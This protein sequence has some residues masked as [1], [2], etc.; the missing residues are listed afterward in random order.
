MQYPPIPNLSE[1]I[2]HYLYLLD[3]APR[4]LFHKVDTRTYERSALSDIKTGA[5]LA[6]SLS[7]QAI[8]GDK[9]A[10]SG[11]WVNKNIAN[12]RAEICYNCPNNVKDLKKSH[13]LQRFNNK[14]AALFT[15][16]R[17]TDYDSALGDCSVCGCPL[18]QKVHYSPEVIKDTTSKKVSPESF[19]ESFMGKNKKRYSCWVRRILENKNE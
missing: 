11:G 13:A 19:P 1:K 3:I 15:T 4:E 2:Q 17:S 14:V 18:A 10:G 9:K 8:T 5:M 7:R 6:L 12:Q 16:L